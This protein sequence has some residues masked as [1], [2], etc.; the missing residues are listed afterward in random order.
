MK[1]NPL[2]LYNKIRSNLSSYVK[3]E[4]IKLPKGQFGQLNKEIYR[5]VNNKG[6]TSEKAIKDVINSKFDKKNQ[7]PYFPFKKEEKNPYFLWLDFIE[8]KDSLISDSDIYIN[9]D[10]IYPGTI[11][12]DKLNYEDHFSEFY[13][14]LNQNNVDGS[15]TTFYMCFVRPLDSQVNPDNYITY[16]DNSPV[17]FNKSKQRYETTFTT[18]EF[19][20]DLFDS[21]GNRV[22]HGWESGG[23]YFKKRDEFEKLIREE[24]VEVEETEKQEESKEKLK[25]EKDKLKINELKDI[26]KSLES[27]EDKIMK[28]LEFDVIETKEAK[29]ELKKLRKEI[30]RINKKIEKITDEL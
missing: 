5:T 4:G 24:P 23:E 20:G 30:D 6:K 28:Q 16:S 18:C 17:V 19:T 21:N 1:Q 2:L 13:Q 15:D 25:F 14:F 10:T 3:D 27:T 22:T 12:Y 9:I 8:T 7:E 29:E 11:H 26:R